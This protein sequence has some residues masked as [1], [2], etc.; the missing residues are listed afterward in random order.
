[1]QRKPNTCLPVTSQPHN[2]NFTHSS[3]LESPTSGTQTYLSPEDFLCVVSDCELEFRLKKPSQMV[4]F[5]Q[6]LC[7]IVYYAVVQQ[8]K[9]FG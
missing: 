7:C 4:L 8:L 3:S 9:I 2:V 5:Q 6:K 1:M